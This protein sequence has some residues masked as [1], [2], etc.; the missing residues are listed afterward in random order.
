M[1]SMPLPSRQPCTSLRLSTTLALTAITP[2]EIE[3]LTQGAANCTSEA[4]AAVLEVS[5][6]LF[7]STVSRMTRSQRVTLSRLFDAFFEDP[8]DQDRIHR[9]IDI[10]L[11][12]P[13]AHH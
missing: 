11:D 10:L 4:E 3:I 5:I 6:K 8:H 1:E 12:A 2:K 9:M 13:P 7:F